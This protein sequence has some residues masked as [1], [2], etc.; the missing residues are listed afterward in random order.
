MTGTFDTTFT[1]RLTIGV[2]A[3][4]PPTINP[5][6]QSGGVKQTDENIRIFRAFRARRLS[7]S[8]RA[9]PPAGR[10]PQAAGRRP[11]DSARRPQAAGRRPQAGR[12]RPQAAGRRP[13]AAGRRPQAAGR[14]T[15]PALGAYTARRT[16]GRLC[17]LSGSG[18]SRGAACPDPDS[19]YNRPHSIWPI[20]ATIGVRRTA[21]PQAGQPA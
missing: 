3:V 11:G 8:G 18:R 4:I 7:G 19:R 17:G 14:A 12:L 9:T 5:S 16:A 2:S 6:P 15:P 13:Q 10:R 1:T 20:V 21:R